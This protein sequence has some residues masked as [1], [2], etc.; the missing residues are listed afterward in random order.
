M[1]SR[2]LCL[3]LAAALLFPLSAR[4]DALSD[5]A[6]FL[7]D[8]SGVSPQPARSER[9]LSYWDGYAPAQLAVSFDLSHALAL[10]GIMNG[11]R[12]FRVLS[13]T[14]P[15]AEE[16]LSLARAIL[17]RYTQLNGGLTLAVR[18]VSP[19]GT[20]TVRSAQEAR[21]FLTD[22]ASPLLDANPQEERSA[23]YR[24]YIGNRN[25][26][27]FHYPSCPSAEEMREENRVTFPSRE[28]ALSAGFRPCR[29]CEP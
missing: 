24:L 14:L 10:L 6:A 7:R 8:T 22:S 18:I 19:A 3:L 16:T 12:S 29:R 28:D 11:P 9:L 21:Y 2:L 5:I 15:G 4:G 20:T 13:F 17:E 27:V 23:S 25:S 26:H 1:R